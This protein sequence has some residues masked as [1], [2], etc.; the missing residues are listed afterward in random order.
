[1]LSLDFDVIQYLNT[2]LRGKSVVAYKVADRPALKGLSIVSDIGAN[3]T[4]KT[5]GD[6]SKVVVVVINSKRADI[7]FK[8][9]KAK[10]EFVKT[11]HSSGFKYRKDTWGYK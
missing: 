6:Y 4:T 10:I 11:L 8:T 3:L 9:S 1:M 2:T 7:R 5:I